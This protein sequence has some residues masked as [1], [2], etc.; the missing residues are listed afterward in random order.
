MNQTLR[1]KGIDKLTS[2]PAWALVAA[3]GT[4][5]CMY[6]FRKPYTA[7]TYNNTSFLGADYKTLLIIA[8][9]LAM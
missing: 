5:F 9:T 7:A 1:L 2:N 3:F 8:Q 6:G 4:Y